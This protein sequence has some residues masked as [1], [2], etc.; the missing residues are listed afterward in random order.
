MAP[1]IVNDL[2][3]ATVGETK[4]RKMLKDTGASKE[5]ID[6]FFEASQI[7]ATYKKPEAGTM[8]KIAAPP[9]SFQVDIVLM[10]SYKNISKFLLL[11]DV[12]SRK[13]FA[14]VLKSG[15]MRDVVD[16]SGKF[17]DE[18]GRINSIT[19]DNYFDSVYFRKIN[20]TNKIA[21]YFDVAADDHIGG[22]G[23]GNRLGIIVRLVRS[24]KSYMSRYKLVYEDNNWPKYLDEIVQMYNNLPHRSLK[25]K[26]P[27]EVFMDDR[28]NS[29]DYVDRVTHN[30][31]VNAKFEVG[32]Q[33]RIL[34]PKRLF[35][36]EGPVLSSKVYFIEANVGYKY[37]LEGLKR[38]VRAT[39]MRMWDGVEPLALHDE[40]DK[41]VTRKL[42][43][44]L[45]MIDN[46][47]GES[48]LPQN[49]SGAAKETLPSRYG[50]RPRKKKAQTD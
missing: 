23:K 47:P 3:L 33:V 46:K 19:G 11:V 40:G 37:K 17:L 22:S 1:K 31:K 14:Y 36:K 50:L 7:H 16:A 43:R 26:T 44:E 29:E 24:L 45:R 13:A 5:L 39:E 12:F 18:I 27:E 21:T 8:Y 35:G 9:K 15:E 2:E 34:E 4:L 30:T 28:L 20:D 49:N 32:D 10:P 42:A 38:K 6:S 25:G 48:N 41:K